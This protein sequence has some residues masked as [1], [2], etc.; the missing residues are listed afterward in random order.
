MKPNPGVVMQ[1][2][3]KRSSRPREQRILSTEVYKVM[4]WAEN[5][6]KFDAIVNRGYV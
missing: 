1:K 2:K 3:E 4:V 5:G 6:E